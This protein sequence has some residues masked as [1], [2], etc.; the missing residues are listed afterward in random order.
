MPAGS[1]FETHV[2][3]RVPY[4]LYVLHTVLV[5]EIVINCTAYLTF[6]ELC[7]DGYFSSLPYVH[8]HSDTA[9]LCSG[10]G[11]YLIHAPLPYCPTDPTT[12]WQ[13][14]GV[15]QVSPLILIYCHPAFSAFLQ[16]CP[17]HH[18]CLSPLIVILPSKAFA[19]NS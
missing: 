14:R 3:W 16:Q 8:P 2:R 7:L 9:A 11:S 15:G 6:C 18:K 19:L 1:V 4:I 17:V 13:P 5:I 10:Y 12:L